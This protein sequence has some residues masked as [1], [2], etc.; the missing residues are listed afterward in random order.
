MPEPAT[1]KPRRSLDPDK[2][3]ALV[4]EIAAHLAYRQR[5]NIA[6]SGHT[7][8]RLLLAVG[9]LVGK[10]VTFADGTTPPG[11]IEPQ[12]VPAPKREL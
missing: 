1:L 6:H 3:A 8:R 12:T 11:Y 4:A 9:A 5:H 10:P 2:A 7:V